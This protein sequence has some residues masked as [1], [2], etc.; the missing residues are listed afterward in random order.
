MVDSAVAKTADLR[1]AVR[2]KELGVPEKWVSRQFENNSEELFATCLTV[3]TA[4]TTTLNQP[5][6]LLKTGLSEIYWYE[7]STTMY[8]CNKTY[9]S[10]FKK[11]PAKENNISLSV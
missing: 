7:Q 10:L 4:A 3:T 5:I 11:G 9:Y 2:K 6:T 8:C 1:L